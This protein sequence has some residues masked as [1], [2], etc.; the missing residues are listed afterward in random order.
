MLVWLELVTGVGIFVPSPGGS[1]S[2]DAVGAVCTGAD[3]VGST[4]ADG[5]STVAT[6][7]GGGA[8][9]RGVV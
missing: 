9:D 5:E 1:R 4:G 3:E 8:E 7:G 2:T 6:A